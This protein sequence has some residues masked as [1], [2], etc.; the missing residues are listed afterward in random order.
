M[1]SSEFKAF[2]N[3]KSLRF[4]TSCVT[5]VAACPVS[6]IIAPDTAPSR[7]PSPAI[8]P[9]SSRFCTVQVYGPAA[10]GFV[11][12]RQGRQTGAHP[13]A[14]GGAHTR[15]GAPARVPGRA[16]HPRA[17]MA[18]K[19]S[20]RARNLDPGKPLPIYRSE[21]EGPAI[22]QEQGSRSVVQMPTGM[23][24]E[25]E[26]VCGHAC[27][28][29]RRRRPP[30]GAS[31]ARRTAD[32]AREAGSKSWS[33]LTHPALSRQEKHIAAAIQSARSEAAIIIPVPETTEDVPHYK[34]R[35]PQPR[36]AVASWPLYR[37]GDTRELSRR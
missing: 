18:T 22:L 19:L 15:R 16:L 12:A 9:F 11:L 33:L 4:L 24:K 36:P 8:G 14:H 3:L 30:R 20:F 35:H 5:A 37:P 28:P 26:T 32:A 29:A 25:E 34:V 7:P 23:E 31:V 6:H 17:T 10:S 1:T 21:E 2:K 27:T 13:L